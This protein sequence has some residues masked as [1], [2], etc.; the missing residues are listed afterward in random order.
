MQSQAIFT[1]GEDGK[2]KAWQTSAALNEDE[3]QEAETEL[4]RK[5]KKKDRAKAEDEK[6]RFKPY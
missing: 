4:P 5:R 3:M 2:I 6:A 1:A